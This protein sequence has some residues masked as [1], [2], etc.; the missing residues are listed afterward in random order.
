[1]LD[2][3][4]SSDIYRGKRSFYPFPHL[5]FLFLKNVLKGGE[6]V[7]LFVCCYTYQ[8]SLSNGRIVSHIALCGI[9]FDL[10]YW[11]NYQSN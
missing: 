6:Y 7:I 10:S 2:M 9:W 1:M 4:E 5:N 8:Y 3:Y 11:G